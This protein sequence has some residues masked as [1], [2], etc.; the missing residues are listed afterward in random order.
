METFNQKQLIDKIQ[1]VTLITL[2]NSL[3]WNC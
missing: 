1:R 2:S 3:A